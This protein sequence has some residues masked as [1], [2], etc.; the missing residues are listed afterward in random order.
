VVHL[1][2]K[3][4]D[5]DPKFTPRPFSI[6][7]C[8]LHLVAAALAVHR[9]VL[10]T[11]ESHCCCAAAKAPTQRR[12]GCTVN[13]VRLFGSTNTTTGQIECRRKYGVRVQRQSQKSRGY[14]SAMC[15]LVSQFASSLREYGTATSNNAGKAVMSGRC[16]F[17]AHNRRRQE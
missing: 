8:L 11:L 10:V 5:R 6:D 17:G 15:G 4:G 12:T 9:E 16:C 7:R 2:P 13:I 3:S 1:P 14:Q